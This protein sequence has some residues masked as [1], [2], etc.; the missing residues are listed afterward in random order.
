[1]LDL[2]KQVVGAFAAPLPLALV[3]GVMAVTCRWRGRLRPAKVLWILSAV[4]V[5]VG[6]MTPIGNALLR[7]LEDCYQ[8]LAMSRLPKVG[9]VVVLGSGYSPRDDLP[10]TAALDKE[11][12]Q[13]IVQGVIL[14][15]RLPNT[16]LVVSGGAPVGRAPPALGYARLARDL[17]VPSSSVIVLDEDPDTYA[18]ARAVAARIGSAPFILV[19]SAYH[20]PRAM[21]LMHHAG[22]DPIAMP[23]GQLAD[24]PLREEGWRVWVPS[25]G[26][27]SRIQLALHEYFG[28]VAARLGVH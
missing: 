8:P 26:G 28:L 22:A 15:R 3:M 13:R 25:S 16:K 27:L 12:L 7:P 21:W 14:A 2:I 9:Y 17:G 5:F 18:E 19:T 10:I 4:I 11:G 1:M 24:V 6:G 20:M 23:T